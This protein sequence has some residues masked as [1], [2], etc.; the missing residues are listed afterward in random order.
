MLN[1]YR[2]PTSS[3]TFAIVAWALRVS[4]PTGAS[5]C[6]AFSATSLTTRHSRRTNFDIASTPSPVHSMSWSAGPM[7]RM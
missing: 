5:P 4:A 1:A 3:V 7:K 6:G 2:R